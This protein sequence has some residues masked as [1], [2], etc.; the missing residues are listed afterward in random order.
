M[1]GVGDGLERDERERERDRKM[2][3]EGEMNI[4]RQMSGRSFGASRS[5]KRC[6]NTWA[7]PFP[8]QDSRWRSNSA[9][10]DTRPG[11]EDIVI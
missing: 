3:R 4:M 7:S 2:E 6:P 9:H 8:V 1:V 10:R 11:R 5:N